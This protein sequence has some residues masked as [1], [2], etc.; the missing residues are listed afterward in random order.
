MVA[1][2]K[3]AIS[4]KETTLLFQSK[5][6]DV[7]FVYQ[8][9]TLEEVPRCFYCGKGDK[10]RLAR[11]YRN[12]HH[13]H[14]IEK[15]G[16]DRRVLFETHDEQL[17]L[18]EEIR[19]IAEMH[20]Y[21][22][23]VE[24]NG[25]GCN[26]TIGGDGVSGHK[27]TPEQQE[28]RKIS[29]TRAWQDPAIRATRI[30]AR[31]RPEVNDKLRPQASASQRRNWQDPVYR[32]SQSIAIKI[33]QNDPQTQTKRRA[34]NAIASKKNWKTNRKKMMSIFQSDAYR[35]KQRQSHVGKLQRCGLC[36]ETG[37]KRRTCKKAQQ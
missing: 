7:W 13:K 33:A 1:L 14:I 22:Y 17:A 26:Y 8:D 5:H 11:L 28:Q 29:Q 16:I 34:S 27:D 21:V 31:N 3:Q 15:H 30:E 20:T 37:H 25:I 2:L 36:G 24:Y 35:E 6:V 32:K 10:R 19:L 23:D 9:W 4:R 12:K 18:N